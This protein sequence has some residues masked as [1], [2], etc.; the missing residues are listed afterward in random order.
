[1]K[2]FILFNRKCSILSHLAVY[3]SS[4]FVLFLC[5]HLSYIVFS[6]LS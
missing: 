2:I 3:Y 5:S 6:Y 1:M 4:H